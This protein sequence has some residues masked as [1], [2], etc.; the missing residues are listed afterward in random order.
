MATDADA[1]IAEWHHDPVHAA[2]QRAGALKWEA[3]YLTYLVKWC[4]QPDGTITPYPASLEHTI[5][6]AWA[7]SSPAGVPLYAPPIGGV[8]AP[9]GSRMRYADGIEEA[10]HRR[11]VLRAAHDMPGVGEGSAKMLRAA[12]A[13]PKAEQWLRVR[14]LEIMY[15]KGTRM[16]ASGNHA[17]RRAI[18][19]RVSVGDAP[20]KDA[21][22]TCAV[23]GHWGGGYAPL[24]HEY[25]IVV[26]RRAR[27]N[28]RQTQWTM[29]ACACMRPRAVTPDLLG[30]MLR[31]ELP[32]ICV[33]D[34][35]TNIL[36]PAAHAWV[37]AVCKH[38]GGGMEPFRA[39]TAAARLSAS[40]CSTMGYSINTDAIA[41]GLSET[42][43]R[44][45]D[46]TART[47]PVTTDIFSALLGTP[48]GVKYWLFPSVQW[49][50]TLYPPEDV[51]RMPVRMMNNVYKV[52]RNDAL[53]LCITPMRVLWDQLRPLPSSAPGKEDAMGVHGGTRLRSIEPAVVFALRNH[54]AAAA[55]AAPNSVVVDEDS[56]YAADLWNSAE[57][58]LTEDRHLYTPMGLLM[59]TTAIPSG[60]HT[61]A[62]NY[63]ERNGCVS[64][65][66]ECGPDAD[67]RHTPGCPVYTRIVWDVLVRIADAVATL[68]ARRAASVHEASDRPTRAFV[69]E[70]MAGGAAGS[71]AQGSPAACA[72]PCC[73]EQAKALVKISYQ[74]GI[75]HPVFTIEGPGGSGKTAF[76]PH[77]A[78][79]PEWSQPGAILFVAYTNQV[80]TMLNAAGAGRTGGGSPAGY[81]AHGKRALTAHMAVRV[82]MGST[83]T[84]VRYGLHNCVRVL[85]VDEAASMPLAVWSHLLALL[86]A[87]N[88]RFDTV[89]AMGDRNQLRP[90]HWGCVLE[91]C[92]TALPETLMTF[93]HQHR[94]DS[95]VDV[96]IARNNK[97]IVERR[98]G[99][100]VFDRR[101]YVC[102]DAGD[103]WDDLYAQ[104]AVNH[105]ARF[106]FGACRR[107][108]DEVQCITYNNGGK[109]NGEEGLSAMWR[110]RLPSAPPPPP[111]PPAAQQ[112]Q[113]SPIVSLRVGDYVS[114]RKTTLGLFKGQRLRIVFVRD[115]PAMRDPR[116]GATQEPSASSPA[117]STFGRALLEDTVARGVDIP[118]TGV[119]VR[120]Q[121]VRAVLLRDCASGVH[122]GVG[123]SGYAVND[124]RLDYARTLHK[125]QGNQ[126][127]VVVGFTS[128]MRSPGGAAKTW[129]FLY[130]LASRVARTP[131]QTPLLV[132]LDTP[133]EVRK[134]V[135][136][137]DPAIR[138]ESGDVVAG[139][140]RA[141]TVAA[142]GARS[143]LDG[144]TEAYLAAECEKERAALEARAA[145]TIARE[146][147][148][149][150]CGPDVTVRYKG[151]G[152]Y[153]QQRRTPGGEIDIL[154]SSGD[155]DGP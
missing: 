52:L 26:V 6:D 11:S 57:K 9:G 41:R 87:H 24:Y 116:P 115:Y 113:R 53:R 89:L 142:V 122:Y 32:F 65:H 1:L 85:V 37:D 18:T 114:P 84:R 28:A 97:A 93:V 136:R 152:K 124:L 34:A 61:D 155:E 123:T 15:N 99:D 63:L 23:T 83:K 139:L 42:S 153:A 22:F 147:A 13:T 101:S 138:D 88:P 8:A 55:A 146:A 43:K 78:R 106:V 94:T 20:G 19:C 30:L 127:P 56:V 141:R 66:C 118:D 21:S 35:E 45:A 100:L 117:A 131:T 104:R 110:A 2:H 120:A 90:V 125:F 38:T 119:L 67:T 98:P 60:S 128:L 121:H 58:N 59:Q 27:A 145:C 36:P 4:T 130:T 74:S 81:G 112:Q 75:L 111:P 29:L 77:M 135:L 72:P 5:N 68:Y 132:L 73:S 86:I 49:L 92:A 44:E 151:G 105:A 103:A 134:M 17:G 82:L 95:T 102:L 148:G 150:T 133:D 126:A 143:T 39:A 51:L 48:D 96:R 76:T 154:E 107:N 137:D 149:V 109:S 70:L 69:H 33:G 47:E 14:P 31:N 7:R 144:A 16:E 46:T 108:A 79:V 12:R 91:L 40:V 25:D 3:N 62:L 10:S 64:M 80:T 50:C 54:L 140:V 71:A 129:R